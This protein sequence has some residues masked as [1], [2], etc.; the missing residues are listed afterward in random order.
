MIFEKS[1]YIFHLDGKMYKHF[2]ISIDVAFSSPPIIAD[3][4]LDGDLEIIGGSGRSL[5]VIDVKESGNNKNYWNMYRGNPERNGFYINSKRHYKPS[6]QKE[7][8]R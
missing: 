6:N 5:D 3:I 2:P 8:I 7:Y 4:D 1:T